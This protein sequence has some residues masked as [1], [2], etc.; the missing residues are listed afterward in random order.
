MKGANAMKKMG[1][2]FGAAVGSI[3][4][5]VSALALAGD[6]SAGGMRRIKKRVTK[7]AHKMGINL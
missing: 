2:M 7:S 5:A 3:V 1:M 4:G 6:L